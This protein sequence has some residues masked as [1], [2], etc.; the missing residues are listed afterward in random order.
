MPM[1]LIKACLARNERLDMPLYEYDCR[2]CKKR[3][4]VILR[5]AELNKAKHVS[6]PRCS[7]A[8]VQKVIEP[9]FAVTARKS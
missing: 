4:T 2:K 9:F 7:S 1:L 3:F 8:D 5:M 6:C